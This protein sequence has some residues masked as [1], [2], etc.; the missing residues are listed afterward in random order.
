MRD[1]QFLDDLG[2]D[3]GLISE[4]NQG[5]VTTGQLGQRIQPDP[6]GR[7]DPLIPFEVLDDIGIEEVDPV[8][9]ILGVSAHN[10][11]YLVD[12]EVSGPLDH[13]LEE[14]VISP[15][16]ELFGTSETLGT[17]RGKNEGCY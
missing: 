5:R 7:C 10:H 13:M 17:T 15:R 6:D 11:P 14:G 9:E 16:L 2:G 12:R 4:N 1:Q 8:N 3:I